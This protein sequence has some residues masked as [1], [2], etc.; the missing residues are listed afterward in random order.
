MYTCAIITLSDKGYIG[1]REDKSG[2]LL[3]EILAAKGYN[4]AEKILLPDHSQML[5][6]TLKRLCDQQKVNLIVTTGGTGMAP[7]DI[8]PEATAQVIE[9]ETPGLAEYMRIKSAAI[10]E[11]AILSRGKCGIRKSSLIIN[12]P[13]SP[14]AAQECIS[15]IIDQLEHGLDMLNQNDGECARI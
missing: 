5:I 7:T 12:L 1:Q 10:T 4:I 11:R 9:R 15:F 8:T 14:K 13:G 2:P 3:A 6:D